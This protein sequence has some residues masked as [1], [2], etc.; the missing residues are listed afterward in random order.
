M[1]HVQNL[2][3]GSQLMLGL[4]LTGCIPP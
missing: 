3:F 1:C 2:Q 4:C